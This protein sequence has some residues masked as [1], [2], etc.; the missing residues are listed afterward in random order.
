M[1][2]ATN[3]TNFKLNKNQLEEVILFWVCAAGKNG[4][5][6]AKCLD[7]LL[8]SW[9]SKAK[10]LNP[11]PSP[12]QIIKHIDLVA[13]LPQEM[14][15]VGI[16]CYNNK[17]KTFLALANS[18]LNLKTCSVDDLEAIPGIGPKTARC[19]LIHSRENQKYAGLDTHVLKFLR[20]KGHAVPKSTPSGKKYKE[21]E[22]IFLKY[23]EA[24]GKSV[25]ELDLAIWNLYR[26]G[27][28]LAYA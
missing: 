28:N 18:D 5:T 19:F 6:A 7:K 15:K 26:K 11:K 20:D 12:F 25:A 13:S 16:G 21:L 10:T 4:V 8:L 23:V 17:S 9:D 1:V 22:Q 2:D 24:S 27:G 14:K 3:I